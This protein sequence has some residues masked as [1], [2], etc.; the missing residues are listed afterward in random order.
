VITVGCM[1]RAQRTAELEQRL[2]VESP[3]KDG[4][5]YVTLDDVAVGRVRRTGDGLW[6]GEW[7]AGWHPLP[8]RLET[9]HGE[10]AETWAAHEVAHLLA[11]E[12]ETRDRLN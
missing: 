4:W 5:R 9:E 1:D 6:E 8:T 10:R 3:G 11:V 2:R 12:K 7:R